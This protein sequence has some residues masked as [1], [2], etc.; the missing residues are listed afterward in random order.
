MSNKSSIT[1]FLLLIFS[2]VLL[3]STV[4]M[5]TFISISYGLGA[6]ASIQSVADAKNITAILQQSVANS[7]ILYHAILTGYII[8]V[9]TLSMFLIAF[10][11]YNYNQNSTGSKAKWYLMVHG[12]LTLIFVLLFYIS[13]T[14][15]ISTISEYYVWAVYFSIFICI[16]IDS[17]LLLF[18]YTLPFNISKTKTKNLLINPKMPYTNLLKLREEIFLH[19]TEKVMIVDKHMNSIGIENLHR[20]MQG[21]SSVSAIEILTSKE[22]L[23]EDFWKNYLDY[24]AEGKNLKMDI[25]IMIMNDED[26]AVQHERFILDG[27]NAYKI[28]PFNII[29]KKSE[30]IIRIKYSEAKRRFDELQKKAIKYENFVSKNGKSVNDVI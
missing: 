16:T 11:F 27:K 23:D 6:G 21:N 1:A 3:V 2:L 7:Q 12:L 30:H 22:M 20:L 8:F 14:T 4:L 5:I 10:M 19:F 24:K 28:P 13:F 9:I 25:N 15:I 17:Y 18:K 26:S 29:H